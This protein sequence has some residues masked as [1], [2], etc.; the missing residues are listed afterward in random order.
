MIIPCPVIL[1]H[2]TSVVQQGP[3]FSL[4]EAVRL[5]EE[6]YGLRP[7]A[8]PLPSER[9]QNFLLRDDRGEQFVLKIANSDEAL[10]V[11]D[12]QNKVVTF[13]GGSDT[14]LDWPRAVA[15]RYQREFPKS[16][17]TSETRRVMWKVL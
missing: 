3:H 1:T 14:G 16:E 2:V 5:A 12:L 11:L 4:A 13:L 7:I 15:E 9:D 17:V 8:E 6:Y 10:E